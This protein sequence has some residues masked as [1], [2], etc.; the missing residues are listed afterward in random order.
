MLLKGIGRRV[1]YASLVA[2]VLV[3]AQGGS[4]EA[5]E[6]IVVTGSLIRG[7]PVDATLPVEVYT[8]A[9]LEMTG[10]P[11]AL[12]FAKSLT[13]SGPTSGEAYYFGGAD[14]TGNVQYNLRG[15]GSDK[16]L[17][18]FNGRR[19]ITQNASVIPQA[20]LHR[21]EVLKDGAAVTYGADATGGV[22]NFISRT[23]FE[24]FEASASYK[25]IDGSDGDYTVS[26]LGGFGGDVTNVLVA[27]EYERRSE[28]RATERSFT[29]LPYEVNPAP[30]STLTNLAGW[31]PRGGLP[32]NPSWTPGDTLATGEWGALLGATISDF[33]QESC[34]AVGGVWVT[35]NGCAYNYIP[36]YNLVE[37][38]NIYRL[39]AQ[40][41]TA[42]TDRMDFHL[43]ASFARVDTPHAYG[44]P[45]QPVIRGPALVPGVSHQFYVPA[46]NPYVAEFME[47]TGWSENPLA[48][49]TQGFTANSY[50]AF[51]HG[52]NE[53]FAHGSNASMPRRIDHRYWHVFTGIDGEMFNDIRYDF[54]ITYNQRFSYVD[55]PDLI[56]YRL[57]EAL[58]GFG[59]P[60][61]TAPDLN[62]NRFGTQNP[63]LA[64]SAD[65]GCHWYNPF[66][67]NFAGQ[68]VLGLDNPSYGGADFENDPEV[69]RW[70]FA[71]R[72]QETVT[73]N[74]TA[75]LLFQ[76][77]LPLQ[78]PG[79]EP[80]WGVGA[81]WRQT[82]LRQS[83]PDPLYNGNQVCPWPAEL[84]H[85]I[86]TSQ[87]D[88]DYHG[89]TEEGPGPFQFFGINVP[90]SNAQDQV[91]Y[92]VE[93]QLPLHDRVHAILAV[94]H[95]DF[96]KGLDATV[97]K[98][99]G[100]V[101]ATENLSFR[102]GYGTNYQAPGA[103][104]IFGN[105][106]NEVNSYSVAGGAWLGT[107]TFT[108]FDIEPETATVWNVGTVWQSRGITDDSFFRLIVDFFNIET[109]DELGFLA[110]ANQI[111][112]AV[113]HL[114]PLVPGGRN[115]ADCSHPLAGRVQF[116]GTC[117]DGV[118][119][120]ADFASVRRDYGNGPGQHTQGFDVQATY[121][122]PVYRGDLRIGLNAT[123]ITK[124]EIG[125]T[126]LDGYEID[127]GSDRLG[128]LNF[129]TIA[130]SASV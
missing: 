119:T 42:V 99:S 109:K 55:N 126:L 47:R 31:L 4:P 53:L 120:A 44:S 24:G 84:G 82:K 65:H 48:A 76:G 10:S 88:P 73:W 117:T 33:T 23:R 93:L 91:S 30:W 22:V 5:V 110:T 61:C 43:R 9:D 20:A 71:K 15:I 70:L 63:A 28:L 80:V 103:D 39:Y 114:D 8:A 72:E 118:T 85:Q 64:G 41:N 62:P 125:P 34:E 105:V 113:F 101:K 12:E 77:S 89:C 94:R 69:I 21:I 3:F 96:G 14:L 35:V 79:G 59:G 26:L 52:G 95:E 122:F 6:E 127:A 57:Q 13:I 54:G 98:V 128:Y 107:S 32:A 36:Y 29:N 74:V 16:T 87:F 66:A 27:A 11:T 46:A 56:A 130:S 83:V 102:G 7:T 123:R 112:D 92:F 108:R 49:F 25:Y 18:L 1:A 2:P 90:S 104:L 129:A 51:A 68:P 86:P 75:D 81:Q 111:A 17:T 60:N 37:D 40:M 50:R 97:Y 100:Q 121:S 116:N 45:S 115:A 78:L 19:M 124:F 67:S 58:N 38:N 106:T